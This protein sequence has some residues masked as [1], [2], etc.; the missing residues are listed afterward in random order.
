MMTVM[1]ANTVQGRVV[2]LH[3]LSSYWPAAGKNAISWTKFHRHRERSIEHKRPRAIELSMNRNPVKRLLSPFTK[4]KRW[5][6]YL[7]SIVFVVWCLVKHMDKFTF[8][9]LLPNS[10]IYYFKYTTAAG[11][12]LIFSLRN[13]SSVTGDSTRL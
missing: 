1:N 8:T 6:C 13:F 2:S 4:Q 3:I 5:S 12:K 10:L 9:L 7:H 11:F